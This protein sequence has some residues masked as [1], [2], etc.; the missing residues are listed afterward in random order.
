M[1]VH[2]LYHSLKKYLLSTISCWEIG[3][4]HEL[5]IQNQKAE[6]IGGTYT[7]AIYDNPG[8]QNSIKAY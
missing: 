3:K 8:Q 5:K 1:I 2:R 4:T 6:V 7:T